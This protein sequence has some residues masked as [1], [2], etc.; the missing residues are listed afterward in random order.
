MKFKEYMLSF[1]SLVMCIGIFTL[2]AFE[3]ALALLFALLFFAFVLAFAIYFAKCQEQRE[4]INSLLSLVE[5]TIKS[6]DKT[7][8]LLQALVKSEKE[9][10]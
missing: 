5:E 9:E 4:V 8:L 2:A 10:N 1:L 6:G 7:V 3:S